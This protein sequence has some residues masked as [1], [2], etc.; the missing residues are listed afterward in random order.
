MKVYWFVEFGDSH[1]ISA[2]YQQN[3]MLVDY[4]ISHV[5]LNNCQS[6]CRSETP[7]ANRLTLA[8][9]DFSP[10]TFPSSPSLRDT[11]FR[12]FHS[13]QGITYARDMYVQRD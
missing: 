10:K 4:G 3:L 12:E 8:R 9:K 2:D 11:S 1:K 6:D 7:R 5:V 13:I